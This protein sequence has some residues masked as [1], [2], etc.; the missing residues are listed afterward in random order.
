MARNHYAVLGLGSFGAK[1]AVALAR[2]GNTV[3]VVDI[4]QQRVDDLRDK[5]TEAI[6]A[7]VSNEEVVR[8]LN[9]RKFDAVILGRRVSARSSSRRIRRFRSGFCSGSAPTRCSSP[10][11][12]W[13]NGSPGG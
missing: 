1:L 9:V 3:L 8:E 6:I 4:D 2:A 12:M 11:R 13:P 7:D 10:S 5:V